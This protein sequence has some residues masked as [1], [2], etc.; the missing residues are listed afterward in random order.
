M[1][2]SLGDQDRLADALLDRIID[3]QLLVAW[4]GETGRLSWWRADATDPAGGGDFFRRWLPTT[5]AMASLDAARQAARAVDEQARRA[6][7]QSE[8]QDAFLTLFHLGSAVD[9]QVEDRFRARRSQGELQPPMG[10]F[11]R[12]NLARD[13]ARLGSRPI[14]ETTPSGRRLS[15]PTSSVSRPAVEALVLGL[16][17]AD[18][19]PPAYPMPHYDDRVRG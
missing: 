9:R 4:A 14:M 15:R 12:V 13:L 2:P 5:G 19:F 7:V 1:P 3:L 16:L 6:A 17:D 11:D 10:E 8:D 18:D